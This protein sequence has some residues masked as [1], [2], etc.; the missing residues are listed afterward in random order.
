MSSQFRWLATIVCFVLTVWGS[1]AL[2]ENNPTRFE[3][4]A[5]FANM[6]QRTEPGPLAPSPGFW[7]SFGVPFAPRLT[8]ETQLAWFPGS[9]P[10][11]F[12]LQGGQALQLG[13]GVRGILFENRRVSF[14]GLVQP[15]LVRFSNTGI[16]FDA[17]GPATHVTLG[18]GLGF[19][20]HLSDRISTRIDGLS[21]LYAYSGTFAEGQPVRIT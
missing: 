13:V 3:I 18:L 15:G 10:A 7:V 11:G 14:S 16:A 4:G 6:W 2:A 21:T 8:L 5:G 9:A 19:D 17:L 12:M 20:I 1:P